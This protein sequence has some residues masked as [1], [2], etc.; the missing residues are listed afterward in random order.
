MLHVVFASF[1]DN[2][3]LMRHTGVLLWP[4]GFSTA[5]YVKVINNP[6]IIMGYRNTLFILF[7][8]VAMSLIMTSLGAYFLSRKNVYFKMPIM[9]LFTFTMFFGGGLIPFYLNLRN[10]GLLNTRWGL[11]IPFCLSTYNMIIMRTSFMT[12]PDSLTEAAI[13][14]GAGHI[15]ILFRVILP[16]SKAVIAVMILYY[17]I[18]IW[19]SWFWATA[20]LRDRNLYP[21]Q[22]ILREILIQNSAVAASAAFDGVDASEVAETIKFATIVVATVPVLLVYPFLQKYFAKGVLLGSIKE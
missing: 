2:L 21:L 18:G 5:A 3:L 22:V 6:N 8:G 13:I 12:I 14:D 9:L 1:S 19:N 17:G 4:R 16:L 7:F 15:Q 10:L 11:I 20:I